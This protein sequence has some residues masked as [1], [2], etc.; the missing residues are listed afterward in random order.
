[1]IRRLNKM[2][3]Q[4]L[5]TRLDGLSAEAEQAR[6]II[7]QEQKELRK[8]L[9]QIQ[10]VKGNPPVSAERRKLSQQ[11]S[12]KETRQYG[13]CGETAGTQQRYRSFSTG[14]RYR[15]APLTQFP[16]VNGRPRSQSSST[17]IRLGKDDPSGVFRRLSRG[18]NGTN[19]NSPSD[20]W[21]GTST[22][23]KCNDKPRQRSLST[24]TYP[25]F[26]AWE[27]VSKNDEVTTGLKRDDMG[28]STTAEF[29]KSGASRTW[30]QDHLNLELT[31]SP[32]WEIGRAHV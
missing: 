5:G 25:R 2:E 16:L 22:F 19:R 20:A 31:Q 14:D 7:S 29:E 4:R 6:S 13:S 9:I 32:T 17:P 24:G 28:A 3:T 15:G 21:P 10:E 18:S 11:L 23:V 30:R 12:C 27:A 8:Q 26:S 1:M